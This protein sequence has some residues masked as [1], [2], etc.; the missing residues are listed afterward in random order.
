MRRLTGDSPGA[1]QALQEALAIYR[2]VGD[3]DGEAEALNE[4]GTLH[5]VCGDLSAAG[6]CHRKALDLAR[7]IG[8]SW[9]EAH[10]LVGLGRQ[11]QL[12][13]HAEYAWLHVGSLAVRCARITAASAG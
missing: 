5:R 7:E 10:A 4:A 3:R 11:G 13:H 6:S 1:A 2:D 9:D 12:P 8:M